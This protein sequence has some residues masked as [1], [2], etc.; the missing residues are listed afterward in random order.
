MVFTKCDFVVVGAGIS[1]VYCAYRLLQQFPECNVVVIEK[2]EYIGGRAL[3]K[4]FHDTPLNMGAGVVRL[5]DVH[6]IRLCMSL[7]IPL[8]KSVSKIQYSGKYDKRKLLEEFKDKVG[9]NILNIKKRKMSMHQCLIN[10]FDDEY[11]KSFLSHSFY[12]DYLDADVQKTIVD[13]PLDEI[14]L[15]E[16]N[17]Y[18]FVK[19]DTLIN[20]LILPSMQFRLSEGVYRVHETESGVYVFTDKN[21]YICTR[22]FIC[23]DIS[24]KNI[25]FNKSYPFLENIGS[26]PFFRAYGYFSEGH[27]ISVSIKT[28][29]IFDKYIPINKNICMITYCDNEKARRMDALIKNQELNIQYINKIYNKNMDDYICKYW[30][31]G[32]HYYKP[33]ISYND[34]YSPIERCC[35]VVFLG[36][37]VS[38]NQ[39]WVEGCIETVDTYFD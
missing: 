14:L 32:I 2:Q 12:T 24:V 23:G 15:E 22:L 34:V 28:N 31:H 3:V 11:I 36:E 37:M 13:Y 35:K 21:K 5:S 20:R 6:L 17:T 29:D 19:W 38:R 7:Y 9:K 30:E 1:G 8:K 33:H 39:G 16:K 25:L 18:Y 4:Q 26:V 27:N 10:Y